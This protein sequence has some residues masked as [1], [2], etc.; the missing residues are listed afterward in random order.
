MARN[1]AVSVVIVVLVVVVIVGC[2]AAGLFGL[3]KLIG[4]GRMVGNLFSESGDPPTEYQVYVDGYDIDRTPGPNGDI[5]L[6]GL[7]GGVHL[8]SIVT[9][10]KHNGKHKLVEI[11]PNQTANLG[12]V[13]TFDGATIAGTVSRQTAGGGTSLMTGVLVVAVKDAANL[14]QTGVGSPIYL[15]PDSATSPLTYLVAY[16]N[17]EGQYLLGP[18]EYGDYIVIASGAGYY[19]DAAFVEVSEDQDK[20]GVNLLLQDDPSQNPGRVSGA[21]TVASASQVLLTAELDRVYRTPISS[22]LRQQI[23]QLSGIPL[24]PEP[25]FRLRTLTILSD[26]LGHYELDLPAGWHNL[27]AFMFGFQAQ[28][29]GVDVHAETLVTVDFALEAR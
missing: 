26:A 17:E 10:D 29:V 6:A 7:P 1:R 5:D 8:V 12:Q 25:W 18:A 13:N 23:E 2:G 9:A 14:L 24:T 16:T 4:L 3:F 20:S 28:E 19:S 27:Q 21:V 11:D 22:A 15:P